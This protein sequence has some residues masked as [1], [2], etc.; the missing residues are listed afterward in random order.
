MASDFHPFG[1]PATKPTTLSA[2]GF[3]AV[4]LQSLP[5]AIMTQ[6][7]SS[8][9]APSAMSNASQAATHS[10]SS[11]KVT[12]EREGDRITRIEIQCTCGQIIEL[13]CLY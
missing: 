2:H 1:D 13:Q 9:S 12:L 3:Q 4:S 10:A 11:P 7:Q 5:R 6:N 8:E